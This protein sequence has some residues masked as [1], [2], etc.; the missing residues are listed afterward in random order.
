MC[1]N[2]DG[3]FLVPA[4]TVVP[5]AVADDDRITAFGL[6]IEAY[7]AVTEAVER[8]LAAVT[9]LSGAEVGVLL[10]LVR[11]PDH[12]LR[13]SDLAT[14]AGLS[15]SGMTR[16][17]DR[18]EAAGYVER[19]ACP[20]DRRGLEAV[21]TAK[22]RKVVEKIVPAHLASIQR[23]IVEPLGGDLTRLEKTMR[24]LRD[25]ARCP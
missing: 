12:H 6:F 14:G 21:L 15:T 2:H 24:A 22:G 7:A 3:R 11:T 1:N 18:L 8:E 19:K 10:R 5:V 20:N 16:L 13:M 4:S 25:S 9:D 17:V 23:H